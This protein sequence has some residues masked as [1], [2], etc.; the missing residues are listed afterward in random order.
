MGR[1]SFDDGYDD[2]EDEDGLN[3][4]KDDLVDELFLKDQII[5]VQQENNELLLMEIEQKIL[6][7]ALQFCK[8]SWFWHFR[9]MAGRMK[10]LKKVFRQ[11]KVMVEDNLKI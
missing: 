9:G 5:A 6:E 3:N 1:F 2:D 4:E 11:F 8:S 10:L 7:N